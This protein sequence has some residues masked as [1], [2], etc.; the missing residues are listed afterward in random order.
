[1]G[2]GAARSVP[3]DVQLR[4]GGRMQ[5]RLR[6]KLLQRKCG[7]FLLF[8]THAVPRD[9]SESLLVHESLSSRPL[10]L[11]SSFYPRSA[12]GGHDVCGSRADKPTESCKQTFSCK[13]MSLPYFYLFRHWRQHNAGFQAPSPGFHQ[14][15]VETRQI[16]NWKILL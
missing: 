11:S 15:C 6:E 5:V 2:R 7:R 1:M 3:L 13:D 8:I 16:R 14:F 10:G 4:S 9:S 12:D